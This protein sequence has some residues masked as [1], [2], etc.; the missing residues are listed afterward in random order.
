MPVIQHRIQIVLTVN[1]IPPHLLDPRPF[2]LLKDH[3]VEE[4][5]T[6]L[7]TN[8]LAHDVIDI[9]VR[10]EHFYFHMKQTRLAFD[11]DETTRVL[12]VQ[13]SID[14]NLHV[15]TLVCLDGD[16]GDVGVGVV[17]HNQE[18]CPEK[19]AFHITFSCIH[20]KETSSV[21]KRKS[22][23]A[24]NVL[25]YVGVCFAGIR[26]CLGLLVIPRLRIAL[27]VLV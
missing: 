3:P 5:I 1:R 12:I 19:C 21:P 23:Y 7:N 27:I 15:R 26:S 13:L 8:V 10:V 20:T 18:Q 9:V 6:L 11:P 4:L 25:N 2:S 14:I 17:R 16:A 22:I 24:E